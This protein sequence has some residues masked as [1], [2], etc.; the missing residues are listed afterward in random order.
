MTGAKLRA[1]HCRQLGLFCKRS[2]VFTYA[3]DWLEL[4][5]DKVR[6]EK[7]GS[8]SE[9]ALVENLREVMKAV[10]SAFMFSSEKLT[11]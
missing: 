11:R 5:L 8:A 10:S 2:Q 9:K 4:A 1:S 3:V 7:D 6:K